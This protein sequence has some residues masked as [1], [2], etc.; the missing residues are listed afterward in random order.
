MFFP[1][2]GNPP[3]HYSG[4]CCSEE[5][6]LRRLQR[7]CGLVLGQLGCRGPGPV[8]AANGESVGDTGLCDFASALPPHQEAH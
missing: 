3:W 4:G 2:L 1:Q 8:D 5:D 7:F 6:W